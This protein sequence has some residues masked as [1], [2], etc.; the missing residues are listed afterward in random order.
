MTRDIPG[1]FLLPLDISRG[2]GNSWQPA[3]T[4]QSFN[5]GRRTRPGEE[6]MTPVAAVDRLF[7]A[8]LN[9]ADLDVSIAFYRDRLGFELAHLVPARRAAFFWIG[10]RGES[11]L[12]LW[13]SGA[14]PHKMTTHIAF[15]AAADDVIASPQRLQSAGVVPL[16]F[17]GQPTD[18]PV[19]LAWMPA[20]AVYFLDPDGHLL[21]YIA[22]LEG[23]PRPDE[24]PV[25]WR[26]WRES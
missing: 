19:V 16:D 24:G 5:G 21:E 15:A 26:A 10:A 17:D 23:E 20:V 7:E 18:E 3:S 14:G 9:V 11:M 25:A 4:F 8:H 1:I 2:G 22:M 13:Q 6:P 12:G